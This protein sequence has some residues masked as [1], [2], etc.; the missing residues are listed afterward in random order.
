MKLTNGVFHFILYFRFGPIIGL[1]SLRPIKKG[2]ELFANYGYTEGPSWYQEVRKEFEKN[3]VKGPLQ[4]K[5]ENNDN[6]V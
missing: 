6:E 3:L 1:M 2:E 4:R 5:F